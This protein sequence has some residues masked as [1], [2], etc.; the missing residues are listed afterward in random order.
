MY[1]LRKYHGDRVQSLSYDANNQAFSVGIILPGE[2]QFGAIREEIYT[3]SHGKIWAW[4][5]GD[6][7]YK[8]HKTGETF[9]IPVSKNFTLKVEEPSAY[10][11]HYR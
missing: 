8:P 10:I 5:E 1:E 2:Y 6:N 7:D 3:V 4:A 9:L 11:C